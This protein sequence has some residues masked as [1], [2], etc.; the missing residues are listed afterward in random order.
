MGKKTKEEEETRGG[1]R[2]TGSEDNR[3][4]LND[5]I[6]NRNIIIQIRVGL[7]SKFKV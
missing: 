3:L 1:T 6:T 2:K 4:G 5:K 7:H